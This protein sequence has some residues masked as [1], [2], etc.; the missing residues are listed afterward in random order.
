[1]STEQ[2]RKNLMELLDG[3][4]NGRLMQ[5]FDKFY[6]DDVVMME[7]AEPD[8]KRIGKEANRAYE[9]FFADNAQWHG[10]K[11]GPVLADGDNTAYEMWMDLTFMGQRMQRT[12]VAL[13]TWKD[14]KIVKEVFYYKA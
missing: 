10:A 3:L 6:A 1:M 7:N 8:P 5:V 13:Q 9:Q 11:L 12:Q 14:G 2:N 4:A